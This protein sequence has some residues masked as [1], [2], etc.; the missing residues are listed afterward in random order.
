[1]TKII[2]PSI[3]SADFSKL[4]EEIKAVED[5]GAGWIHLDVMDGHFVSNLTMGPALAKSVRPV[6]K[7]PFDAHLMV[8]QPIEFVEAFAKAGVNYISI[9]CES[10]RPNETIMAIREFGAKPG[11]VVNPPTKVEEAFPFL[12]K[13]DY[14]LVMTVNPGFSGQKLIEEAAAK[15]DVL[16]DYREKNKLKYFIEVDGGVNL[17]TIGR[18]KNADVFVAASAIFG[19]DDYAKAISGLKALL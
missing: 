12:D 14:V 18:V 17:E 16:K 13:V 11:I 6:T 1:M 15:V 9:H 2:A 10:E 5:A 19:T 7:L 3:L 4:G 8:E